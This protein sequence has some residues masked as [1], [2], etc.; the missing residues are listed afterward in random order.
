MVVSKIINRKKFNTDIEKG[1]YKILPC[2]D[3]EK[4]TKSS[5]EY[6]Y[7]QVEYT[8]SSLHKS[9]FFVAVC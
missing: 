7:F 8:N 5:K 9:T 1:I 3:A 2:K 6:E 4:A